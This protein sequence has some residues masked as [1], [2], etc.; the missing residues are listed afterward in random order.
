MRYDGE[1]FDLLINES[2]EIEFE[3]GLETAVAMS[4]WTNRRVDL[5]QL[6]I[7]SKDQMGWWG[8]LTS[9]IQGDQIGSRL[10]LLER[11]KVTTEVL[12]RSEDYS[13][14]CLQWMIDDGIARSINVSS[15]YTLSKVMVTVIEIEKP[16][17]EENIRYEVNWEGQSLRRL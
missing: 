13:V 9:D 11:E 7:L 4:L 14:E 3:D 1:V 12:R 17:Q 2:N 10:W 5:S 16:E 6:S 8:D 15:S